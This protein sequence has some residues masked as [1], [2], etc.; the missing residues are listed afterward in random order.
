MYKVA[1]ALIVTVVVS[2]TLFLLT[3]GGKAA[4]MDERD[5]IRQVFVDHF[6]SFLMVPKAEVF[7]ANTH[8]PLL[9]AG[10]GKIETTTKAWWR[11]EFA[12]RNDAIKRFQ[13]EKHVD[14][15]TPMLL[16]QKKIAEGFARNG[17]VTLLDDRTAVML[18][19]GNKIGEDL[20]YAYH[21][22]KGVTI[23][24]KEGD[25][26]IVGFDGINKDWDQELI[27]KLIPLDAGLAE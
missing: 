19:D 25:N 15:A 17:H 3:S 5:Q 27:P 2:V 12:R 22:T 9:L 7:F 16:S 14:L 13:E 24:I 20:G 18:W 4:D 23:L 11:K 6:A 26:W 21:T 1:C 10:K 8:F